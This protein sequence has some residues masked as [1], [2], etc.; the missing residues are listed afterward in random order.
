MWRRL[1]CSLA[2]ALAVATCSGPP[3]EEHKQA[4]GA[5]AAAR[6]ADAATYAPQELQDAEAARK[7]YDDAVAQRDYRQ[8]LNDALE[9]RDR[10]YEAIKQA[11]NAKVEARKQAD[12][13][14]VELE[15]LNKIGTAKLAAPAARSAGPATERLRGALQAANSALQEART[16]LGTL[17]YRG[18]VNALT[19]AVQALRRELPPAERVAPKRKR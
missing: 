1:A 10:A 9:A 5:I 8:A 2:V 4:E 17:D 18:A 7:K 11:G 19:P 6:A 12:A 13:L 3:V 15:A 14:I 16:L